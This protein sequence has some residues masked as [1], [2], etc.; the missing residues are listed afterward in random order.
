[1]KVVPSAAEKEDG[2]KLTTTK[3]DSHG[4]DGRLALEEEM[5]GEKVLEKRRGVLERLRRMNRHE[6]FEGF[7]AA[8]LEAADRELSATFRKFVCSLSVYVV[9]LLLLVFTTLRDRAEGN[10]YRLRA[11]HIDMLSEW[12]DPDSDASFSVHGIGSAEEI[13]SYIGR[14]SPPLSSSSFSFSCSS[15]SSSPSLFAL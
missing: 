4:E 14:W 6:D 3:L 5:A 7:E 12:R 8:D 2:P 9:F 15:S 1:M 11:Q 10:A 13:W